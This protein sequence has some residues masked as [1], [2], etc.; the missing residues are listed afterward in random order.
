MHAIQLKAKNIY[1][2]RTVCSQLD[3]MNEQNELEIYIVI[4]I[5][6]LM[7]IMIISIINCNSAFFGVF[8]QC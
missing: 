2:G 4:V 1:E 8:I 5:I 7:I 6:V 3:E